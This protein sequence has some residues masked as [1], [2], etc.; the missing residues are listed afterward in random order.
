MSAHRLQCET[1]L[2]GDVSV[3]HVDDEPDFA[4]LVATKLEEAAD[5][6]SVEWVTDPGVVPDRVATGEIDCVL[7]DYAMGEQ[8]GI[9]LLKTLREVSP[10]LP[11]I[12]LTDTGSEAIASD[13]ISA[14]VSD[15]MLKT[16]LEDRY[17]LLASTILTHVDRRRATIAARNTARQLEEITDH[18]DAALFLFEFDWQ[19]L[20]FINDRYATIFGQP[21][22]TL[23]AEPTA[24]LD[25]V[26]P[27][28]VD[29]LTAAMQRVSEGARAEV[30][31]RVGDD[32]VTWVESVAKPVFD[33][34]GE[35][36]RIAGYSRDISERV[37]R[38]NE[39]REQNERLERFASIVSHDLRNPLSV[40]KGY[41]GLV[42]EAIGDDGTLADHL[43][44]VGR[45]LE[46]MERL[47]SDM[48]TLAREGQDVTDP[49]PVSLGAVVRSSWASID[50][51]GATL[52]VDVDGAVVVADEIRLAQ[53]FENLFRNSVE[54]GST[55]SRTQSD[56]AVEH[57][58]SAIT[59]RVGLLD[60]DTGIYVENDGEPIPEA[61]RGRI[62]ESGFTTNKDGTGF[63]TAIIGRIVRAHG[64][65]ISLADGADVRFEIRGMAFVGES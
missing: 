50:Q 4:R 27:A 14:G 64:W 61:Y 49:A 24:F 35:V 46:R 51:Q 21:V 3:L 5:R 48:L 40:A 37:V 41:L 19:T 34:H 31:Y 11:V 16:R 45:A 15:Y 53:V 60:D 1:E 47:I 52:V 33:E 18:S 13:A 32:P 38:E 55:S 22:E 30:V 10:E 26:H 12:M 54:H 43:E 9:A 23:R 17:P 28:D 29:E 62:F 6:L 44:T 58:G 8:T 2:D 59:I 39:L 65:S 36:Y 56:D 7:T 20:V 57:G 63:G 42:R 25:R